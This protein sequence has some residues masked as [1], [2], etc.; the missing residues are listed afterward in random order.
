MVTVKIISEERKYFNRT[1][2]NVNLNNIEEYL[3]QKV[4]T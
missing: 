2:I 3:R 4:Q 1:T